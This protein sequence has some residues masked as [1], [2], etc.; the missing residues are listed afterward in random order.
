M[1]ELQ[2]SHRL[3]VLVVASE[4]C[5][6]AF[7]QAVCL[8]SLILT[9]WICETGRKSKPFKQN[10]ERCKLRLKRRALT[11]YRAKP[12][13]YSSPLWRSGGGCFCFKHRGWP[14]ALNKHYF[15]T[16]ATLY[17]FLFRR[18][19]VCRHARPLSLRGLPPGL[20]DRSHPRAGSQV[21]NVSELSC[22]HFP[23]RHVAGIWL[24]LLLLI[25]GVVST[26]QVSAA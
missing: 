6:N 18:P 21:G 15:W 19:S 1:S 9:I 8:S 23:V 20:Y 25:T 10:S 5:K 7:L 16:L 14:G 12:F 22:P 2:E 4:V 11:W 13:A 24:S 26:S 17:R 3:Y